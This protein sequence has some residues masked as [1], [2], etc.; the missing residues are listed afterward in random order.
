MLAGDCVALGDAE[1]PYA[2]IVA[3]LRGLERARGRGDR[4]P[5]GAGTRAVAAPARRAATPRRPPAPSPRARLFELLLA[6]LGRL[7]GDGEPLLLVIEDLHWADRS[8]RDFLAFLIRTA[9][10]ERLALVATYRTDELH[11]RHPLRPF[12]AEPSARRR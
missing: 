8:T 3:A 10:R 5:G 7:A 4:R 2:P 9:R 11:R 6:L 1:L 12:L